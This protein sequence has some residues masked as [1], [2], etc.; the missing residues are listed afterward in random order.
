MGVARP[1]GFNRTTARRT[2]RVFTGEA[3]FEVAVM[4]GGAGT[5][6]GVLG[7]ACAEGSGAAAAGFAASARLLP[8]SFSC[9]TT[10]AT[11]AT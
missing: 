3:T 4:A 10:L 1:F 7:V 11:E 5:N 6:A 2:P 9:G 8:S